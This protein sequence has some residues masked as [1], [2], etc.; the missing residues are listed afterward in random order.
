MHYIKKDLLCAVPMTFIQNTTRTVSTSNKCLWC[1]NKVNFQKQRG[2]FYIS[3]FFRIYSR[4]FFKLAYME[5][6]YQI[7]ISIKNVQEFHCF[8]LTSKC[9]DKL[10]TCTLSMKLVLYRKALYFLKQFLSCFIILN[11]ISF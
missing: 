9:I 3:F 1:Q 7:F 6:I 5:M 2:N 11:P 8:P 4:L 10:K